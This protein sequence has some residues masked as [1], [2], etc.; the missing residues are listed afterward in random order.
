MLCVSTAGLPFLEG[1]GT[2]P[3]HSPRLVPSPTIG[4]LASGAPPPNELSQAFVGGL[5]ELGYIEGQNIRVEYRWTEQDP[6]RLSVLA[7]ELVRL[8]V[9]VILATGNPPAL[10]AKRAT[11]TIPIVVASSGGPVEAG[12]VASMARPG[13]NLTG[14][15]ILAP[16]LSAKRLGLL[17]EAVP[18]ATRVAV[19]ANTAAATGAGEAAWEET[20]GAAR[21]LG[22]ELHHLDVRRPNDLEAAFEA[23]TRESADALFLLPAVLFTREQTRIAELAARHRLP[24]IYQFREFADA[25][26]LMAYGPSLTAMYRRSAAYVDRILKGADPADLPVEGPTSFDFVINFK[27]AQAL[28]LTIPEFV[29]EQATEVIE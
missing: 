15:S 26:G 5:R 11:G 10:A 8:N 1:C 12:L 7:A 14:L 17:K 21:L 18:N 9:D 20:R 16:Q 25:G 6:E 29:L 4:Y 27:A 19:L 2:S 22:L 13:G 28:G 24:A 3:A 23:A